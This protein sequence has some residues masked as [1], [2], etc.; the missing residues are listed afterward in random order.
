MKSLCYT[1]TRDLLER[2]RQL[3][4]GHSREQL[5]VLGLPWPPPPNW[6]RQVLGLRLTQAEVNRL[7]E[8]PAYPV[9][10]EDN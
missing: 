5:A 7:L 10:Q 2:A 1:V 8:R 4:G 9:H 3:G 6:E